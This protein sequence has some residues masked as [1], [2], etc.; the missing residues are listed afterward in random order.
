M[1][2]MFPHHEIVCS[3]EMPHMTLL[4][5]LE[6]SVQAIQSR[7]D[8]IGYKCEDCI[9]GSLPI[10]KQRISMCSEDILRT[11]SAVK[12]KQRPVGDD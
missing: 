2:L 9:R 12:R 6:A 4:E 5:A 1:L 7:M 11:F 3:F 10:Q 8:V